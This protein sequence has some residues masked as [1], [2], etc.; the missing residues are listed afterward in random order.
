[1][2]RSANS[3]T[4]SVCMTPS[5]D[6]TLRISS[7][8]SIPRGASLLLALA[9]GIGCGGDG[10]GAGTDTEA[11]TGSSSTTNAP[12]TLDTSTGPGELTSSTTAAVDDTGTSSSTGSPSTDSSSGP[13]SSS[14]DGDSSSS[15][16]SSDSGST[17]SSSSSEGE[18]SSSGGDQFVCPP[19]GGQ[20]C[21]DPIECASNA[22]FVVG[23]LG[24][25]CSECD[26]DADCAW[27]CTPAN[28]LTADCATCCDGSQGCGCETDAACQAGLPCRTIFEIPGILSH[29]SCSQCESDLDCAGGELCAPEY[30]LDQLLG[31]YVCVPAGSRLIDEGCDE[32]GSGDAQCASGNCAPA[33]IM[34][35][36]IMSVCSVC[37]ADADCP[38]GQQCTLPEVVI[39][40]NNLEI[41]SGYCS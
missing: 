18:S 33:A 11:S 36:P 13:G 29:S 34:G 19:A 7:L 15:S 25:V 10:P 2:R 16:S 20:A 14:S 31:Q 23:P 3:I 24:G 8:S 27:G 39:N 6:T 17:G 35:I 26:E 12:T 41:A 37:D 21:T 9:L 1:M 5:I 32:T 38:A 40:G 28:P 30:R 4:M 22:C